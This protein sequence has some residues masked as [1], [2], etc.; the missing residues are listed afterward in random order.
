MRVLFLEPF[1]GGSHQRF[2]KGL[3]SHSRHRIDLVSLPARFWKWRMR[4]AALYFYDCLSAM[5]QYDVLI[6]T[7]LMSLSD[8]KALC[9]SGF[10]PAILYFHEN[11]LTY[12]LAPGEKMDLQYGFTDITSALAADC[13]LF[14]S[15]SHRDAFL[16]AL[17]EFLGRLPE[18]RPH[19]VVKAIQRKSSVLY[20][21]VDTSGTSP[22]TPCRYHE[23]PLIIWNHRW[24]FDKN[25]EDFFAA[26]ETVAGQGHHFRIALLGQNFNKV[27]TIYVKAC[28]QFKG[29]IVQFGPVSSRAEYLAW[30]GQGDIVISTAIQENFGFSVVEA[31]CSGCIPLLPE[32]L[33]YPEIIPKRFHKAFLYTDQADFES[34]L[35]FLL[36]HL[37]QFQEK[38]K[39]VAKSMN[40]FAWDNL[41]SSYDETIEK[42]GKDRK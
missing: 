9:G 13:V 21:G 16:A 11:Q 12:P 23:E 37:E 8:F 39:Q 35:S 38:Q 18:Y 15:R 28:E 42:L 26:L 17:P 24:E 5:D 6:T 36:S 4:G 19:W 33:S 7:D 31:I 3:T 32:R 1:C 29:Q 10:P 34:R 2:V 30:L 25:P 14:N 41:I 40:A 27:P 20:P 22:D